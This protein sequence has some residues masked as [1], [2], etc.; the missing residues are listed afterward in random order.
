MGDTPYRRK[1]AVCIRKDLHT[2]SHQ[3]EGNS[4][5]Q[6]LVHVGDFQSAILTGCDEYA[7]NSAHSLMAPSNSS[8]LPIFMLPGDNDWND[9][10]QPDTA[11]EHF[12]NYFGRFEELWDL[13]H[14]HVQRQ[15]SRE[16]NFS[17]Y[18]GGVLFVGMNIVG[19]SVHDP[20]EWM[21]RLEDNMEWFMESVAQPKSNGNLRAI[22]IFG[23]AQPRNVHNTLFDPLAQEIK[24]LGYPTLYVCG[25]SH[26]WQVAHNFKD[27]PN[28]T[29]INVDM[30]R[31][32]P[33]VRLTVD[34]EESPDNILGIFKVE[35]ESRDTGGGCGGGAGLIQ[36]QWEQTCS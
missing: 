5:G 33:P 3:E 35:C 20:V 25:D 11:W 6:F 1:D 16:E 19:G 26:V 7:Y 13:S 31:Y 29:K 14:L 21:E 30:G 27:V 22:V 36:S 24:N 10:P 28:W 9:C 2:I 34:T 4:D 32:A 18:K 17:I 15:K 8:K 23:H 12:W